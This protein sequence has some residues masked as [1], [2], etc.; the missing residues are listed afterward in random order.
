ME[1]SHWLTLSRVICLTAPDAEL[2]KIAPFSSP[3]S[4]ARLS[5]Y[6][7]TSTPP[8]PPAPTAVPRRSIVFFK[9]HTVTVVMASALAE[10][11]GAGSGRRLAI[12]SSG[13]WILAPVG[14]DGYP[15]LGVR[16]VIGHS[17]VVVGLAF[18]ATLKL[19]IC[20]RGELFVCRKVHGRCFQHAIERDKVGF[21]KMVAFSRGRDC[22]HR[23][24]SVR[25]GS[26]FSWI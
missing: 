19:D 7:Q 2:D 11:Y 5:S 1:P 9:M 21:L 13:Y 12:C 22:S 15:V 3:V 20:L 24:F 6:R 26:T 10:A 23:F 4:L 25:A 14:G 18:R 17:W 8:P 16:Y